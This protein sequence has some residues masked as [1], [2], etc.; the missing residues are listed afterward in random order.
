[1]DLKELEARAKAEFADLPGFTTEWHGPGWLGL[2]WDGSFHFAGNTGPDS[3]H[4]DEPELV[5]V[6]CRT[7]TDYCL[8]TWQQLTIE[9][10]LDLAKDYFRLNSPCHSWKATPPGLVDLESPWS[11]L[12]ERLASRVK[13]E[14]TENGAILTT[15]K[16]KLALTYTVGLVTATVDDWS[17]LLCLGIDRADDILRIIIGF[18]DNAELVQI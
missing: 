18:F 11:A 3:P 10:A 16:G 14:R 6:L 15:G 9:Q 4:P 13:V 5:M 17:E 1:M 8:K 2:H 7:T 12:L